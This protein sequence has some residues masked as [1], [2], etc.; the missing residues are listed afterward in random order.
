MIEVPTRTKT[1]VDR[2]TIFA[3]NAE[4][5]TNCMHRLERALEVGRVLQNIKTFSSCNFF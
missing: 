3:I 4:K 5:S 1:V 2:G